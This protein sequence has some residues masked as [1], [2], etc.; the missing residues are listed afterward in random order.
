MGSFISYLVPVTGQNDQ[1]DKMS[2]RPSQSLVITR[3]TSLY[4][5]SRDAKTRVGG[6]GR[7]WLPTRQQRFEASDLNTSWKSKELA[8]RLNLNRTGGRYWRPENDNSEQDAAGK[9]YTVECRVRR[10]ERIAN[11]EIHYILITL[12]SYY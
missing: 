12:R 5:I 2:R 1:S 11:K 9:N 7:H 8:F 4:L 6:S 3:D 10:S